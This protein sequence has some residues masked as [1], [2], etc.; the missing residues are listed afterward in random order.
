MDSH[1]LEGQRRCT[2]GD[3]SACRG[4]RRPWTEPCRRRAA[5]WRGLELTIPATSGPTL[6]CPITAARARQE[7]ASGRRAGCALLLVR[8]KRATSGRSPPRGHRSLRFARAASTRVADG[9]VVD[10]ASDRHVVQ[11][12][13]V[14]VVGVDWA[15]RRRA[16]RAG[17]GRRPEVAVADRHAGDRR[18]RRRR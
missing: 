14:D 13:V 7:S 18:D 3:R 8:A 15:R 6:I 9:R 10:R 12:D 17:C 11:H 2:S 1:H 4:S 16:R 5:S